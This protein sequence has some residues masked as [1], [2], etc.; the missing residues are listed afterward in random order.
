MMVVVKFIGSLKAVSKKSKF[1]IKTQKAISLKELIE[2]II[3][4]QPSL[5]QALIDQELGGP[6]TKVLVLVNDREIS[7]LNGLETIVN[8]GD[9]VVFVPFVHGG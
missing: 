2:K 7:V 5:K 4:L 8:D 9:E 3:H 1:T 6:Q